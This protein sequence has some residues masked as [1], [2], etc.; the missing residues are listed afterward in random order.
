MAY[1][2]K[3]PPA[4][5]Y[6]AIGGMVRHWVY[7]SPDAAATVDGAGYFTNGQKLG[8]KVGDL[9]EVINTTGNI[10]TLHQ[11]SAVSASGVDLNDATVINQTDTD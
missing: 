10:T 9:V 8:M 1:D 7:K 11:V 2:T 6:Q 4:L 5:V 3:N